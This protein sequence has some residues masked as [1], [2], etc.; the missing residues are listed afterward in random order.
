MWIVYHPIFCEE[1]GFKFLQYQVLRFERQLAL[2]A[3][4]ALALEYI[5]FRR[6]PG[7]SS[8]AGGWLFWLAGPRNTGSEL[9]G[10]HW[11]RADPGKHIFFST[12]PRFDPFQMHFANSPSKLFWIGCWTPEFRRATPKESLTLEIIVKI[13]RVDAII[14]HTYIMIF[15]GWNLS[16]AHPPGTLWIHIVSH[17]LGA[18]CLELGPLF[19]ADLFP[20]LLCKWP[21]WVMG[22][23]VVCFRL[24]DSW[25][26]RRILWSTCH[27]YPNMIWSNYIPMGLSDLEI[28]FSYQYRMASPWCQFL[29]KLRVSHGSG[30]LHRSMPPGEHVT[31]LDGKDKM[32]AIGSLKTIAHVTCCH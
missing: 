18:L 28:R 26:K 32:F 24:N 29:R 23:S 20:Q 3:A 6:W 16:L 9:L 12:R 10:K 13:Y 21:Q 31:R 14:C 7:F 17:K 25:N 4:F 19:L 5:I 15:R 2:L 30:R 22:T 1:I 8:W 27:K 11:I